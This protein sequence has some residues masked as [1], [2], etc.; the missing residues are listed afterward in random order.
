MIKLFDAIMTAVTK[1]LE[2]EETIANF[3]LI[4]HTFTFNV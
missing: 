1:N 2:I 4:S 3:R